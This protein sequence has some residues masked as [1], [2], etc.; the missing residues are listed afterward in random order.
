MIQKIF[1]TDDEILVGHGTVIREFRRLVT[2]IDNTWRNIRTREEKNINISVHKLSLEFFQILRN[3]F[4]K[5]QVP[6]RAFQSNLFEEIVGEAVSAHHMNEC[7]TSKCSIS[8]ILCKAE[9]IPSD[10]LMI[11]LTG[12]LANHLQ[13]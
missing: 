5:L 10:D 2:P 3:P 7:K 11:D 13:L 12:L 1:C 8:P 9:K 4:S 6:I